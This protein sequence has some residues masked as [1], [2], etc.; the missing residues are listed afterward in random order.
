M[1]TDG[2]IVPVEVESLTS[3]EQ[4]LFKKFCPGRGYGAARAQADATAVLDPMWGPVVKARDAWAGDARTRR[5][6]SSGGALTALVAYLLAS[7]KVDA[8]I[9]TI[10]SESDPFRN[11]SVAIRDPADA[12]R[13]SGSRYSPTSPFHALTTVPLTERVAVV[14]KPCD[15]A[16]IRELA[17][18]G[19][20]TLPRIEYYL[21][22]FCAGTPSWSGT[23][24]AVQSLGVGK[25]FVKTITYRGNGWPGEFSVEDTSGARRAMTYEESWGTI[26]N[27]HL[28]NRCKTCQDGMGVHADIVA[29]DSWEVDENGYPVFANK[30]GRSFLITR[31]IRGEGLVGDALNSEF[32]R[33]TETD[34][35]R[36]ST[37]Q[38]SQV[39]RKK[40]AA[41][42]ALG[43]R[44][45]GTL[46]PSFPGFVRWRWAIREPLTALR[47]GVG[48]FRRGWAA[49]MRPGK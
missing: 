27:K 49:R 11:E 5:E 17:S 2:F 33:G 41:Y 14:G 26:L 36:L 29:A 23:E 45:A 20:L 4:Q 28:H 48:S 34:L 22:F 47:Q 15:I 9:G 42:R 1:G 30:E 39:A 13:L 40:F 8:V 12:H 38:P 31:T 43:F 24:Q 18:S 35:A 37:I 25:V 16:S 44:L 7:G 19:G 3:S 21:S 6:G 10:A 46:S 32:L